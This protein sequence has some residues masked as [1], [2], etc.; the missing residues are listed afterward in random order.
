MTELT[1]TEV[2]EHRGV[3]QAA[4]RAELL[5]EIHLSCA[6]MTDAGED[7]RTSLEAELEERRYDE[8]PPWGPSETAYVE[9]GDRFEKAR[10][11]ATRFLLDHGGEVTV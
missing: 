5:D 6:A 3:A 7:L 10:A 2:L 9:T 4:K 8:T 11:A 1:L